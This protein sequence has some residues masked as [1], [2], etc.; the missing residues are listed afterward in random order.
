M[1]CSLISLRY[2]IATRIVTFPIFQMV[3]AALYVLVGGF[4]VYQIFNVSSLE[5]G[6]MML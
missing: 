4:G 5:S 6:E 2:F 1:A 3:A